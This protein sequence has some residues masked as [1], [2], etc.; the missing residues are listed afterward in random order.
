MRFVFLGVYYSSDC[1]LSFRTIVVF[2]PGDKDDI[3]LGDRFPDVEIVL[4]PDLI[5]AAF[6]IVGLN[7][8]EQIDD[9]QFGYISELGI[10]LVKDE[11]L[12]E[13]YRFICPLFIRNARV[14]HNGAYCFSGFSVPILYAERVS[15]IVMNGK[16]RF[17]VH[18]G[19]M[20]DDQGLLFLMG[21]QYSSKNRHIL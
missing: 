12:Q 11:F 7:K 6:K 3:G 17:Y 16:S 20:F 2:A 14:L 10:V 1:F 21:E 19:N 9:D 15:E 5:V 13:P 4:C 18:A 8:S